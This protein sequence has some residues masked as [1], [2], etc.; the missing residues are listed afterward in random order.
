MNIWFS[1]II[2]TRSEMLIC[3]WCW[4]SNIFGKNN[5][6]N[7]TC[8]EFRPLKP[9]G[10]HLCVPHQNQFTIML[11]TTI[12]IFKAS[13]NC[14]HLTKLSHIKIQK[15]TNLYYL[16]MNWHTVGFKYQSSFWVKFEMTF[17]TKYVST[18]A[19]SQN[20]T[21]CLY[22]FKKSYL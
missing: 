18:L 20:F 19:A 13:L 12:K 7:L 22:N 14:K 15:G 11:I 10:G 6:K 16:I 2:E 4:T 3:C 9:T 8:K 17:F 1:K 21:F 5:I